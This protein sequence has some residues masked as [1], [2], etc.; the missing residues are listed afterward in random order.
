MSD[1]SAAVLGMFVT[2]CVPIW[3]FCSYACAHTADLKGYSRLAGGLT[4]LLWGPLALLYYAGLPISARRAGLQDL[5]D[6]EGM[7]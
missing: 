6:R 7:E 1:S 3:L 2:F 5:I 4:G